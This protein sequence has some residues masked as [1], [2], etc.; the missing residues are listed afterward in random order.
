MRRLSVYTGF[1]F[2][3]YTRFGNG[4]TQCLYDGAEAVHV[5]GSY[6][7]DAET[8]Y[9][10]G[11]SFQT[12]YVHCGPRAPFPL[13]AARFASNGLAGVD[14]PV[15]LDSGSYFSEDIQEIVACVTCA[16]VTH[17]T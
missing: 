17:E 16:R 5:F 12:T 7:R 3:G 4:W 11:V 6:Y 8:V 9:H 13:T 15:C 10:D 2:R 1:Q 14:C